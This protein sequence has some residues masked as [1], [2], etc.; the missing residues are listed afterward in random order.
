VTV[1]REEAN[2]STRFI[3]DAV[4]T[5]LPVFYLLSENLAEL[6]KCLKLG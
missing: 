6:W 4:E 3:Y 5:I 2:E 1:S